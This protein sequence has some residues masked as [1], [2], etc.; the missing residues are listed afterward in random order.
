MAFIK[1]K[2]SKENASGMVE[3]SLQNQSA[4]AKQ[5]TVKITLQNGKGNVVSSAQNTLA[6]AKNGSGKTL[7]SLNIKNPLLWSVAHP[8]ISVKG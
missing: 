6:L 8:Y 7:I 5:A 2:V 1:P 4:L 3:V